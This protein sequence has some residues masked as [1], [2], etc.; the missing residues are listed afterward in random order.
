MEPKDKDEKKPRFEPFEPKEMPRE[1]ANKKMEE[2]FSELE[3]ELKDVP[4]EVIEAGAQRVVDFIKGKLSWAEIFNI[5]PEMMKQMVELGYIKFQ[6]GRLEEAERFFKVLTIL[7]VKNSYFHS[8]LG[9]ILKQQKRYGE[10]LV[11]FT[12]AISLNPVDIVSIVNRGEIFMKHGWLADAEADFTKAVA[13]DP[14]A[15][16][17]W[18]NRARIF[19]KQIEQIRKRRKAAKGDVEEVKKAKGKGKGMKAR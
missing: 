4:Q 13:L 5:S 3:R 12:E 6:A 17:K 10:A 18:A 11:R 16:D 14:K 9:S 19:L 8:M 1:E 7:D 2:F 15:E